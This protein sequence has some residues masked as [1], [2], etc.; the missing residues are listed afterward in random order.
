VRLCAAVSTCIVGVRDGCRLRARRRCLNCLR[1]VLPSG[2]TDG[3]IV[4]DGKVSLYRCDE[5][6]D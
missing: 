4:K 3:I 1:I 6:F 2:I 5:K